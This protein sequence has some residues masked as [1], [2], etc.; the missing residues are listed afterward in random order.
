MSLDTT[1]PGTLIEG[2]IALYRQ[3]PNTLKT[4]YIKLLN[5]PSEAAK[6]LA[7]R[8]FVSIVVEDGRL[9]WYLPAARLREETA[10]FVRS[11]LIVS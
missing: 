7:I 9:P 5:D 2:L 1:A 4:I 6:S 3:N 10:G 11:I 8:A